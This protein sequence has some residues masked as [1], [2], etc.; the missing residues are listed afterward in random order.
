MKTSNGKQDACHFMNSTRNSRYLLVSFH[1]LT[2][3][4]QNNITY[5]TRQHNLKYYYT[6]QGILEFFSG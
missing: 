5:R 2:I 6:P 1:T 3:R 4:K